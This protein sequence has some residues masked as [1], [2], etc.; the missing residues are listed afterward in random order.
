MSVRTTA[1]YIAAHPPK[2]NYVSL[3]MG[4]DNAWIIGKVEKIETSAETGRVSITVARANGKRATG[5]VEPDYPVFLHTTD[6][7]VGPW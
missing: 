7:S 5:V 3:W 1:A 4:Y 2:K 6:P